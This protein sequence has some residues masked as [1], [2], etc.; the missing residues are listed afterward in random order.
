M[1]LRPHCTH[2]EGV[3]TFVVRYSSK[4]RKVPTAAQKEKKRGIKHA[5]VGLTRNSPTASST[6]NFKS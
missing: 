3:I 6:G 1:R 5:H 2:V 4:S